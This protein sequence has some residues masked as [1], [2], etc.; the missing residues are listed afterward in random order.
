MSGQTIG[1]LVGG[2]IGAILAAPTGGMSIAMGFSLGATIGGTAGGIIDPMKVRGPRI[3]AGQAQSATDGTPISWVMGTMWTAGTIVDVGERREV[4]KTSGGKGGKPK[5]T[6]YEAHQDF[7][8]LVCESDEIKGS[9]ISNVLAI[10][11]DGKIVYD[12]R[13]GSAI[14]SDSAKFIQN[15]TFYYGDESQLPPALV[16]TIH[17]AGQNP[18]YRGVLLA[19]FSDFNLTPAGDRIPSFRFLVSGGAQLI[20]AQSQYKYIQMV[21]DDHVDYSSP[22]LDDSSWSMGRAPFAGYGT[23]LG[24]SVYDPAH[25]YDADFL[26]GSATAW[27]VSTVMWL[28]SSIY[29]DRL[30]S[31]LQLKTFMDDHMDVYIN[32][33]KVLSTTSGNGGVGTIYNIPATA[34]VIGR[35]VIALKLMDETDGGVGPDSV[36][37]FDMK[38]Y[39]TSGSIDSIPLSDMVSRICIRG[40]VAEIDASDFATTPVLGY[41]IA[42]QMS[43]NDALGPLLGSYFAYASEY[44]GKVNFLFSG[45]DAVLTID[46]D[47]VVD[48]G[49]E[50]VSQ[51]T[52]GN[53]TEYPRRVIGTYYDPDQNY[54]TSTVMATRRASGVTAT[55]DVQ[56]QIPV[57]VPADQAQQAV[58]KAMKVYYAQLD[59]T[60][61]VTLPFAAASNCYLRLVSGDAVIYQGRRW[62]IMNETIGAGT[63]TLALQADRQSAYTSDV[64]AIPGRVPTAPQ[65]MYSGPTKIIP[66]SLPQLQSQDPMGIYVVTYSDPHNPAWR[67]AAIQMSLDSG[68]TWQDVGVSNV[69]GNIGTLTAADD[70]TTLIA[71]FTSDLASVGTPQ[72]DAGQNAAVLIHGTSMEV[73]QFG[74]A[75][76]DEDTADLYALTDLRRAQSGTTQVSGA[77]GDKIVLLDA[78]QVIP[79]DTS[80]SGTTIKFRAVGNGETPDDAVIASV[81]YQPD[82]DVIIDG[83]TPGDGLPP[84]GGA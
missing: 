19:C 9:T 76:E 70:G 65:S 53:A 42:Q 45:A 30:Y 34:L 66:M 36:T 28:R 55:G 74:T 10:E 69:D 14:A 11:Q 2:A 81:V 23:N 67:S 7:V 29:V 54:L 79:I 71:Q 26:S 50:P 60:Q 24:P 47:D 52:R 37:Y 83:G 8:I 35:N 68:A 61:N 43:A 3:G 77:I 46:E 78:A 33:T 82:T 13:P 59:G 18:A 38:V 25:A 49:N 17:G 48:T 39:D 1:T 80:F 72:L 27:P 64:Q 6:T 20:T 22:T 21:T 16:E 57:V 63:V 44:D 73:L 12:V 31:T 41:P 75:T 51:A 4:K 62:V 15:I 5:T 40:G 84:P 58:V 32:G 56:F